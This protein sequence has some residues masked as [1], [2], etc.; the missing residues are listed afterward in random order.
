VLLSD[1]S[2]DRSSGAKMMRGGRPPT[3]RKHWAQQLV[4]GTEVREIGARDSRGGRSRP[5]VTFLILLR[6][7][8]S[9]LPPEYPHSTLPVL[10]SLFKTMP[11]NIRDTP[12]SL[13]S[14]LGVV[15]FP[16]RHTSSHQQPRHILRP[17]RQNGRLHYPCCIFYACVPGTG[18]L[19]DSTPSQPHKNRR[20]WRLPNRRAM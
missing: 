8:E 5:L 6:R 3:R 15:W 10:M 9:S 1:A 11:L 17:S 19:R 16:E 18:A 2:T 14:E 13:S 7:G 4:T 12:V 20:R